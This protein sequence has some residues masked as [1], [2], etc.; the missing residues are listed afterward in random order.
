MATV[1]SHAAES[2]HR[3]SRQSRIPPLEQGDRLTRS[4]FL[5]RYA[6][7]PTHVKAERIEGMVYMPAAAVS[8]EFHGQLTPTL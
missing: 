4:E 1:P 2:M 6:A 8:A 3:D 5:R 7:M